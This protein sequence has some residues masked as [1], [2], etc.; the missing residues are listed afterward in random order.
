MKKILILANGTMSVYHFRREL[1]AALVSEGWQV[2]VSSPEDGF[3][4][5]LRALGITCIDT[6]LDRHGTNPCRDYALIRRYRAMI[7]E[8][9]PKI[10]LTYTIKPN[11]YGNLAAKGLNIPVISVVTGLGDAFLREDMVSRVVKILYR[12]ALEKT[13]C[14]VFLNREDLEF[15]RDTRILAGPG[16]LLSGGEGVN[17]NEFPALDYPEASVISFLYVGRIMRTKGVGELAEAARQLRAEYRE[18]FDLTLIGYHDGDIKDKVEQAEAEGVMRY[19][20]F[21]KDVRPFV[22]TAHCVLLPSYKEGMSVALM[23]AAAMGRPIIATDIGGCREIVEDG[24]NGFLCKPKDVYS[25]YDCMKRFLSLPAERRKEMGAASRRR[26]RAE[27][28]RQT[29]VRA[30]TD[31]IGDTLQL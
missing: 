12:R 21:Q 25:L 5:E 13:A 15:M 8:L 24:V 19:A 9:G 20:G 14:V 23:E 18:A 7:R 17:I 29:A 27:F 4:D 10:L 22:Q 26:A 16:L 1:I 30:M 11:I 6:P 31:L 2:F 28:D 3:S